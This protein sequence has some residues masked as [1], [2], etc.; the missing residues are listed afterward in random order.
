MKIGLRPLISRAS[1]CCRVTSFWTDADSVCSDAIDAVTST[2]SVVAPTCSVASKLKTELGSSLL[3]V[4]Y[5]LKP[6]ASIV[7]A[8][9]PGGMFVM[10]KYPDSLVV[11]WRSRPV[12]LRAV[13]LAFGTK[14][15]EGSFT[16]P[17]I[18][19]LSDCAKQ[20]IQRHNAALKSATTFLTRGILMFCPPENGQA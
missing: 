10:M 12:W 1:I 4:S 3:L 20:A 6:I 15:L 13:T 2:V 8:Y 18:D 9:W 7:T 17:V 5:S 11:V 19:P 14:A 16:K